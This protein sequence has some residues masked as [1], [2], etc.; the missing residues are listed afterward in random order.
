MSDKKDD[1]QH[2]EAFINEDASKANPESGESLKDSD[3]TTE[4]QASS[5]DAPN[6]LLPE[7][8]SQAG[9]DAVSSLSGTMATLSK[10]QD[11]I[12]NNDFGS[13]QAFEDDNI[14]AEVNSNQGFSDVL[15]DAS[16]TTLS[17]EQTPNLP[18]ESDSEDNTSPNTSPADASQVEE[19]QGQVNEDAVALTESS[20][21][22]AVDSGMTA[23]A[24][25]K[26]ARE[27]ANVTELAL[28]AQL[29][30]SVKTLRALEADE[31]HLL[32]G[33]AFSRS[34]VTSICRTIKIDPT[35]IL[36]LMPK[37]PQAK[38]EAT[39]PKGLNLP[40]GGSTIDMSDALG[41]IG[42]RVA[43]FLIAI[44][45]AIV[46]VIN[47][48]SVSSIFSDWSSRM[49]S[50]ETTAI[51]EDAAPVASTEN[52]SV[53]FVA[54]SNVAAVAS[55]ASSVPSVAATTQLPSV[56]SSATATSKLPSV[57]ASLAKASASVASSV[58]AS[59]TNIPAANTTQG[60]NASVAASAS[61]QV[62]TGATVTITFKLSDTSYIEVLEAGGKQLLGKNALKDDEVTVV[63][64]MPAKV[65]V[66]NAIAT[67]VVV[68]G[69]I[70]NTAPYSR[71]NVARFDLK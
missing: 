66:G 40:M 28:A 29:K 31:L 70:Y 62:P 67:T 44:G 9:L 55:T 69:Q 7:E 39:Q 63:A 42:L 6:S 33:V 50:S 35:E 12:Y 52:S 26:Q 47:W 57:V 11:F 14:N 25:L 10:D 43:L 8:L 5:P 68:N 53:A 48:S 49:G 21:A 17:G 4:A 59:K 54:A 45:L 61:T 20:E 15:Q 64:K 58:L 19:T 27:N 71:G 65:K 2:D 3:S 23:G 46:L 18:P 30:V 37:L 51:S 60:V 32:S 13:S 24:L 38:S 56:N 34:L 16:S 41:G 36:A 22:S 1:N